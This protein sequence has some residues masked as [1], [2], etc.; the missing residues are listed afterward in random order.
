MSEF[1]DKIYPIVLEGT[2]IYDPIDRLKYVRYWKD[3]KEALEEEI[4]EIGLAETIAIIGNDYKNYKEIM[5]NIAL[6]ASLISDLN[7][8]NPKLLSKNNF[9][10]IK[11]TIISKINV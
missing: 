7:T 4:K 6:I 8:L 5:D 11:K 9:E 10:E 2:K 1:K 3:K